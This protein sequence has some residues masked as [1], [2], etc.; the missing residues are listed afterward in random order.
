[1]TRARSARPVGPAAKPGGSD[2]SR[3]SVICCEGI[4]MYLT[5]VAV[6]RLLSSSAAVSAPGS[7]LGV[8]FGAEVVT[9]RDPH[10]LLRRLTRLW[11]ERA[12]EPIV[13]EIDP[14]DA[15]DLLTECGWTIEEILPAPALQDRYLDPAELPFRFT[16]AGTFAIAA[17]LPGSLPG[18]GRGVS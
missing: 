11:H 5:P 17:T 10:R 16:H 12:G 13:T 2:P 18:R 6:R 7:R 4:T 15:P 8:E 9:E 14:S 3:P 1:M